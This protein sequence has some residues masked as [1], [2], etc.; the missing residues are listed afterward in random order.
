[1]SKIMITKSLPHEH[2][3]SDLLADMDNPSVIRWTL[4]NQ[5]DALRDYC[6]FFAEQTKI[7]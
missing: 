7:K 2:E 6:A 4:I 1:M 3:I 5:P